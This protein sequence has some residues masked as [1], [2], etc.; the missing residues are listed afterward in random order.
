MFTAAAFGCLAG[1]MVACPGAAAEAAL[2]ALKLWGRAVAPVLGPFMV[3]MLMICS[4]IQGTP[5]LYA[6]LGWLSGSPGGARLCRQLEPTGRS[7]LRLAAMTGTMSPM[8]FLG[9][10]SAWLQDPR[11][12]RAIFACH[13]LGAFLTGLCVPKADKPGKTAQAPSPAPLSLSAAIRESGLALGTVGLC[14]MLGSVSA[15]M[16][17]CAFP[18]LPNGAAAALQCALEVTAG[19]KSLIAVNPPCLK[20][21][22]CAACS[23]G[24]LSLLLQNAAFWQESGV[25]LWQ[26]AALRALHGL[27]SF[28]LCFF[29]LRIL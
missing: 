16:A 7:A 20:A 12:G 10:I 14:M 24:G 19:V 6:A 8:F 2:E 13:L 9:T 23:A 22:V 5:Y 4:R 29:A 18:T 11:A 28:A 25:L 3:C 15:R 17:L 27:L 21:L 26:L 1:A